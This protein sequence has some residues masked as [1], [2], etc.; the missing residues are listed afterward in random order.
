M[1]SRTSDRQLSGGAS[2]RRRERMESDAAIKR[3]DWKL[4]GCVNQSAST[5]IDKNDTNTGKLNNTQSAHSCCSLA[6]LHS[7][8]CASLGVKLD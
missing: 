5:E 1:T 2:V 6:A 8:A 4:R 7:I 3:I